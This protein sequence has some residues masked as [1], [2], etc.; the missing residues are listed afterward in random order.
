[1]LTNTLPCTESQLSSNLQR[2]HVQ[3]DQKWCS[4]TGC[5]EHIFKF[6]CH[7]KHTICL[8]L[9]SVLSFLS[10]YWGKLLYLFVCL[11]VSFSGVPSLFTHTYTHT[12]KF[13]L[14]ALP[15]TFVHIEI[16]S[17]TFELVCL[18][19]E[20]FEKSKFISHAWMLFLVSVMS[21]K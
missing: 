16:Q 18:I 5:E 12:F 3:D 2:S 21:V 13:K 4:Q 9:H 10:Y 6:K 1:M 8:I 7:K 11:C 14:L 15:I 19:Q 17:L 20:N